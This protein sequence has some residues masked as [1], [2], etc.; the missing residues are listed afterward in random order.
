MVTGDVH[1]E[2]AY[3]DVVAVR[4]GSKPRADGRSVSLQ[5][6]MKQAGFTDAEFAKLKQAEDLSNELAKIETV[7]MNM[8]KGQF[9][10]GNGGFTTAGAPDL[11]QARR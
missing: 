9:D 1:H 10:D 11:E 7:A 8:V 4:N 3:Q 2:Q 6:L 5:I